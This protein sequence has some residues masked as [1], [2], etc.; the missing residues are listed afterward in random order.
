MDEVKRI[1]SSDISK[2]MKAKYQLGFTFIGLVNNLIYVL[3]LSS[4]QD[5]AAHFH[6]ESFMGLLTLY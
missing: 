3:I 2:V 4:A 5:V 6:E 1:D